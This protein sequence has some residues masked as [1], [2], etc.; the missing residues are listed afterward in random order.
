MGVVRS[1][2]RAGRWQAW[3]A[4]VSNGSEGLESRF[5]ADL[6]EMGSYLGLEGSGW[7]GV[8]EGMGSKCGE[9]VE[10]TGG[11]PK[12]AELPLLHSSCWTPD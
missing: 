5:R 7:R 4:K 3:A 2:T 11:E 6:E 8:E 1:P 10:W 9:A 12:G